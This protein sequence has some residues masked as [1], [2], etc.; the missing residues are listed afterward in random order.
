VGDECRGVGQWREDRLLLSICG[1][2]GEEVSF[3]LFD[4]ETE[5]VYGIKETMILADD[6]PGSWNTPYTLTADYGNLISQTPDDKLVVTP[7]VIHDHLTVSSRGCTISRLM[8]TDMGGRTV[9]IATDLGTGATIATA[10]LPVGIY[11]LTIVADGHTYYR[12]VRKA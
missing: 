2:K 7:N 11:I 10:S 8:L 3:R 12:K 9:L 4:P 5:L 6:D 1:E